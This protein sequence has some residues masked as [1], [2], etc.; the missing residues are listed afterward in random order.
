MLIIDKGRGVH[1]VGGVKERTMIKGLILGMAAVAVLSAPALAQHAETDLSAHM[2][3]PNVSE[4]ERARPEWFRKFTLSEPASKSPTTELEERPAKDVRLKWLNNGR[5]EFT[6]DLTSRA[7]NS[8]LPREEMSA[9]ATFQITPR[10][11]IG[12]DLSVGGEELNDT[13][14]WTA[15]DLETGI[16]LRSAFKF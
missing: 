16:R 8:P 1:N 3:P 2:S 11:S 5:W 9:G 15:Q 14:T 12:G 4:T 7:D 10:F 13:S 6:V